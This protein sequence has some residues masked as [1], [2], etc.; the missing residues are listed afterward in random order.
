[1]ETVTLDTASVW[2]TADW[3]ILKTTEPFASAATR[4]FA[5][6][7]VSSSLL[8]M[9]PTILAPAGPVSSRMKPHRLIFRGARAGSDPINAS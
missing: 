9:I 3:I 6:S 2:L 1:M 8:F 4:D 7:S 5:S